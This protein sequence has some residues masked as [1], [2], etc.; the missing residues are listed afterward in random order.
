MIPKDNKIFGY[1]SY[2]LCTTRE[3]AECVRKQLIEKEIKSREEIIAEC[4]QKIIRLDR[5]LKG[6]EK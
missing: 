4:S 2:Q 6:W 3:E 5:L 1:N